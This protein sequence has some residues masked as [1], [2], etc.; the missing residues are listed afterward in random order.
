MGQ[1]RNWTPPELP[2]LLPP[3]RPGLATSPI[4][5]VPHIPVKSTDKHSNP[6]PIHDVLQ[7][8][9]QA[10]RNGRLWGRS[11]LRK[12]RVVQRPSAAIR[13]ISAIFH[14]CKQVFSDSRASSTPPPRPHP[15]KARPIHPSRASSRRIRCVTL[16]CKP[17]RTC[18][19]DATNSTDRCVAI[20]HANA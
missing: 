18:C 10:R 20:C 7:R 15:I 11:R 14:P 12:L 5:N 16:P 8:V 3:P 4:L 1:P 9:W 6:T 2:L 17:R 19:S 13:G